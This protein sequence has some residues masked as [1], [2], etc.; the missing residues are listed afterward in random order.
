MEPKVE[1]WRKAA[2]AILAGAPIAVGKGLSRRNFAVVCSSNVNRSIMA[3]ILLEK[4]DMRAKSYGTGREVK[5]PGKDYKSPQSFPFGT[6]YVE[7]RD[8]LANQNEELFRRNSVLGLLERDAATKRAPERWQALDSEEVASFDVVVC[9]ESRVFDL[10]VEDL[11]RREPDTFKPLHVVSMTIRDS[12]EDSAA[13]AAHVLELCKMLDECDD[14]D[15]DA[16]KLLNGFRIGS[17]RTVLHQMLDSG[18]VMDEQDEGLARLT[19][20]DVTWGFDL[21]AFLRDRS[22]ETPAA[23]DAG[24]LHA[25]LQERSQEEPVAG[26]DG[27]GTA[28]TIDSSQG[29]A[30]DASSV[31]AGRAEKVETMGSSQGGAVDASSVQTRG[32]ESSSD[33]SAASGT[34]QGNGEDSPAALSGR[35]A[36]ELSSWGR[37][38]NVKV[39]S[40]AL[41]RLTTCNWLTNSLPKLSLITLSPPETAG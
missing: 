6:P 12:A 36:H 24:D 35:A 15:N 5:L 16:S 41:V 19:D 2:E 39:I 40:G 3:Q 23:S 31:P 7:I 34:D 25:C 9:F 26:D 17:K 30:V 32:A 13:A 8:F 14:L 20:L 28:E 10:V 27:D 4:N 29:G 33:A 11:H 22:Q 1:E 37:L 38:R 18:G 21:H